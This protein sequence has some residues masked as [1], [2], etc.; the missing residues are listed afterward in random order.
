ME[1]RNLQTVWASAAMAS[2]KNGGVCLVSDYRAVNK[3]IKKLP[4]VIPNQEAEWLI[5]WGDMFWKG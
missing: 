5:C 2:P 4:C 1:F 3:K